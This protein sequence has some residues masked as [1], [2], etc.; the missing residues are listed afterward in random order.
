MRRERAILGVPGATCLGLDSA[1]RLELSM[2]EK[3]GV[4][5]LH[6]YRECRSAL[7]NGHLA[8]RTACHQR[9]H[10]FSGLQTRDTTPR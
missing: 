1:W 5:R 7:T 2:L 6:V 10:I 4:S 3:R 8:I 9:H